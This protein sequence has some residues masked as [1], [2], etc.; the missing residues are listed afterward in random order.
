MFFFDDDSMERLIDT[1]KKNML[2]NFLMDLGLDEKSAQFVNCLADA[3]CPIDSIMKG[4]IDFA[5]KGQDGNQHE[6]KI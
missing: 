1:C 4:I 6:S 5:K 2:I 3:G